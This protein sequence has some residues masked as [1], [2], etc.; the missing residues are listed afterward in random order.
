MLLK[1]F[2]SSSIKYRTRFAYRSL[3]I[4]PLRPNSF[5]HCF[6]CS[7]ILSK[8][9]LTCTSSGIFF[10]L[11]GSFDVFK[12]CSKQFNYGM[13][14]LIYFGTNVVHILTFVWRLGRFIS[15]DFIP[16][17]YLTFYILSLLDYAQKYHLV[18]VIIALYLYIQNC[19]YAFDRIEFNIWRYLIIN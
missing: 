6:R 9:S 5:D 10:E 17:V 2:N 19:L 15:H 14:N 7:S 18:G 12:A 8:R 1:Y 3:M 16:F 11:T 4:S 13:V